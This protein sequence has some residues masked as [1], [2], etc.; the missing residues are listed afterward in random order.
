MNKSTIRKIFM[1]VSE[2]DF[3][4]LGEERINDLID[5]INAG[6]T[7]D[8]LLEQNEGGRNFDYQNSFEIAVEIL[9]ALK[10]LHQIYRDYRKG[11]MEEKVLKEK[12]KEALAKH[13]KKLS[14]EEKNKLVIEIEKVENE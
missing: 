9:T 6:H 5:H 4:E 11:Q 10:V 13:T 3:Q 8:T 1:E 12:V 14:K 7:I 2:H